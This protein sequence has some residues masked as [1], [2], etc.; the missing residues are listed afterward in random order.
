MHDSRVVQKERELNI[1]AL[2]ETKVKR[3]GL[4]EWEGQRVTVFGVSERCRARE[5]M[6]VMLSGRM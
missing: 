5:G 2:S 1:L 3:S 6:A 4:T